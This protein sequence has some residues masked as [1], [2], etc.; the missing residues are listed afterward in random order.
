MKNQ[1]FQHSHHGI[2]CTLF[3]ITQYYNVCR[4][5]TLLGQSLCQ[6]LR[7]VVSELLERIKDQG[8]IFIYCDDLS[9]VGCRMSVVGWWSKV[10]VGQSASK[11]QTSRKCT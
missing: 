8:C 11:Y 10:K 9:D 6:L 4:V 3:N 2:I 7:L 1:E 5:L